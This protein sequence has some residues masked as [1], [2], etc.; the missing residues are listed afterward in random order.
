[1]LLN[2]L[3][4]ILLMP[5]DLAV[6]DSQLTGVF[7]KDLGIEADAQIVDVIIGLCKAFLKSSS[8][9][10]SQ[11]AS[12]CLGKLFS[13]KDIKE[14]D[15]LEK[16][17]NWAIARI[18]ESENDPLTAF[19]VAG[20][21]ASLD[22]IFKLLLRDDLIKLV[23]AVHASLF[24]TERVCLANSASTVRLARTKLAQR[25]ALVI[26]RP[27]LCTWMH[28]RTKKS[29]LDNFKGQL[30]TSI[31]QTNVALFRESGKKDQ[32]NLEEMNE[33]LDDDV[34][35]DILENLMGF[36]FDSLKDKETTVRWAAAKSLGRI[37]QRLDLDLADDIVNE[38]V[39]TFLHAGEN[40]WHG[41]LMALGELARRGLLLPSNLPR[42]VPLLKRGLIFEIAQG[43]YTSGAN[44]RDAACY[45][46]WAFSRAYEPEIMAP[47]VHDLASSLLLC[48]LY[49]KEAS[50][51]RAAAA[52]FQENVGR[53]GNFP[54]GIEIITEAD[55]FSLGVR[56][57]AYLIVSVFVAHYK[58]YFKYFAEHLCKVKL[59]HCDLEIRKLAGATLA[60]LAPMDPE[61]MVQELIPWLLPNCTHTSF[62]ARHGAILGLGQILVGLAGRNTEHCLKDSMKDSVFLRSMTV[63]ERKMINPGEYMKKFQADYEAMRVVNHIELIS[64]DAK[65][66]ILKVVSDI[67]S[68]RLYRGKGGD[69]MRVIVS[70]FIHDVSL[71]KLKVTKVVHNRFLET[72]D[73]NLRNPIEVVS[74]E[75]ELALLEF[76]QVYHKKPGEESASF[77]AK[78][79]D[80]SLTDALVTTRRG[81][82]MAVSA[83]SPELLQANVDKVLEIFNKNIEINKKKAEDDPDLR[84]I[85]VKGLRRVF[86]RVDKS[87]LTQERVDLFLERLVYCM[88]DYSV[89]RRGDIGSMVRE[90][91]MYGMAELFAVYCSG[92]LPADQYSPLTPQTV[93]RL[94][95]LLI[96]QL[97]EKIDRVR[98][99]A[100]S[101]LQSI[102]DRFAAKLPDF[103]GKEVMVQTFGNASL[104]EQV[105]RDQEKME[106]K[107]DVS[108][109]DTTFLDYDKNEQLI[110]FWDVPTCV[111][112]RIVPLLRF[113]EYS[114][115]TVRGLCLSLGGITLSTSDSSVKA[116][117]DFVLG[118]LGDKAELAHR[119]IDNF[120]AILEKYKKKERFI[121]PAFNTLAFFFKMNDFFAGPGF[122]EKHLRLA[123]IIFDELIDTKHA[124][125]VAVAHAAGCRRGS[126]GL[127]G[128]SDLH[129]LAS[130]DAR[131]QSAA[132]RQVDPQADEPPAEPRVSWIHTDSRPSPKPS[133]RASTSRSRP[134]S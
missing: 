107:F 58:E 36:I 34:D 82:T 105:K 100:G 86:Q 121:T 71:A 21:Y 108:L 127:P 96:Q 69:Q 32:E 53:Q 85:S 130:L 126:A 68:K 84:N 64:A 76:S 54:K 73:E 90:T 92:E 48:A 50:C 6:L 78:M 22:Q 95:G 19:H 3:A 28:K 102:V 97:V 41:G 14:K 98:L 87:C 129:E 119:L 81:Y 24:A 106:N 134:S 10:T 77:V 11:S 27:K 122:E 7:H 79:L 47:F 74:K 114:Y 16:Y 59:A 61:F 103:P 23:P 111:F 46:A 4:L 43:T 8:S 51:R 12:V 2:W 88:E 75:A 52:A 39:D 118:Y 83:L 35:L 33:G 133:A 49:D 37:T 20:I 29:L 104:R 60:L 115:P 57:N 109:V 70:R 113:P 55:Y 62:Y 15:W 117:D 63:N 13:R 101:I 30:D 25:M 99:I 110:Y 31:I 17:V 45:V 67:E 40:E 72:L 26:L 94:F 128:H 1:M 66:E 112:P 132:Q 93:L 44:V 5:F 65:K 125:K 56:N 89:D 38:T 131:E 116:V 9:I 18:L 120:F 124:S 123:Q 91:A 42:V 80:K